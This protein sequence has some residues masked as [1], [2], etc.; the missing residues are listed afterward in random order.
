MQNG[1]LLEIVNHI[2]RKKDKELFTELKPE[3]SLA[4]DLGFDSLDLAELTVRIED[5]F[6]VDIFEDGFV[7]TVSEILAKLK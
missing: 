1:K 5:E 7:R 6:D 2:R 4:A 3:Y